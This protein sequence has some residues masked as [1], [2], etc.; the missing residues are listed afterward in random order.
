MTLPEGDSDRQPAGR[1]RVGSPLSRF[2]LR[3]KAGAGGFP[4]RRSTLRASQ[5]RW[6]ASCAGSPH[7]RG[8]RPLVHPPLGRLGVSGLGARQRGSIQD[9]NERDHRSRLHKILDTTTNAPTTPT[10]IVSV[11][12][13]ELSP[14]MSRT[15]TSR[16]FP[17][18]L[19]RSTIACSPLVFAR[20]S[21]GTAKSSAPITAPIKPH[22]TVFQAALA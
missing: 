15:G 6:H 4:P 19:Y 9:F 10:K 22:F 5:N 13:M 20:I 18:P 12:M 8:C 17:V 21:A 11:G 2:P 3:G 16:P 1:E 14:V 7:K